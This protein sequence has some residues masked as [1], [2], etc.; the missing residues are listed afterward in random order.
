MR[1]FACPLVIAALAVAVPALAEERPLT[2]GERMPPLTGQLLTGREG[3]LPSLAHGRVALVMLG[4][5]YASRH[6]V[7]AWAE[8]WRARFGRDTLVTLY[9]VPMIGGMGRIARPFIQGSMRRGTPKELHGNVMTVFGDTRPWRQRLGWTGARRDH[10]Y[11]LLLDRTGTVRWLHASPH[12]PG[13]EAFAEAE[14]EAVRLAG[15]PQP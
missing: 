3:E 7:E 11:L 14:R 6:G 1:W 15:E 5:S 4:F 10:A 12:G 8:R 13:E 2:P 9:E